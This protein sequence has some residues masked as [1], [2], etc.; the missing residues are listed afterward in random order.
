MP[1]EIYYHIFDWE[2]NSTVLELT[3][4]LPS[5]EKMRYLKAGGQC[6]GGLPA[7]SMTSSQKS[8]ADLPPP[9]SVFD[10]LLKAL[11]STIQLVGSL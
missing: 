3:F 2:H 5:A 4:N 9:A 8:S 1:L 11:D 10:R 7:T 6:R